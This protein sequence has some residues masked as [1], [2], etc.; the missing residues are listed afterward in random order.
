MMRTK[1]HRAKVTEVNLHYEGSLTLDLNLMEELNILPHE[2]VQVVNMNNAVRLVTYVIPGERNSGT[3]ALNGAA[4]RLAQLGD[5]VLLIFYA[6]MT[7]EEALNHRPRVAILDEHNNIVE[8][9]QPEEHG[10]LHR[11]TKH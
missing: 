5:T 1:V 11:P 9:R 3:V 6:L 2:Q 8:I 7:E 4:A 10:V